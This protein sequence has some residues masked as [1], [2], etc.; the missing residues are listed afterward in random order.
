MR[1][2]IKFAAVCFI[3]LGCVLIT[4]GCTT[5]QKRF[6]LGDP[7]LAQPPSDIPFRQPCGY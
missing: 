1:S 2:K 4:Q 6:W 5:A 3:I 7:D